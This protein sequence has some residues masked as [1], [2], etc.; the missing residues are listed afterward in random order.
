MSTPPPY[1][2]RSNEYD[3]SSQAW[4]CGG[5]AHGLPCPL[6]PSQLGVC[7]AVCTPVKD[8]DRYYCNHASELAGTCDEGP[9]PDGECCQVPPQCA[10]S[11]QA[12]QWVCNRGKCQ[13]GPLPDGTCSMK[14]ASCRPVRGVMA[15][16]RH[17]VFAVLGLAL[18]GL[19]IM[20]SIPQRVDIVSPGTLTS[21]H[22]GGSGCQDC[23]AIGEGDL[24]DWVDAALHPASQSSQSERCLKCHQELGDSAMFAH[25]LAPELLAQTTHD[26]STPTDASS[27][28]LLL[29][30]ARLTK[31]EANDE[32]ACRSC[33]T[34]H[35]GENFD[36]TAMVDLKCQLCHSQTFSSFNHGHPEI[37]DYWYPRRTRL[38]FNHASHE[39]VHAANFQ[40][41]T[42]GVR[43]ASEGAAHAL[44]CTHCHF[45]DASGKSMLTRGYEE[46]CASCHDHQIVDHLAS[47]IE[48]LR[49]PAP[50]APANDAAHAQTPFMR[51]LMPESVAQLEYETEAQQDTLQEGPSPTMLWSL[52]S[53]LLHH[54]RLGLQQRLQ[55]SLGS[56]ATPEDIERLAATLTH[57]DLPFAD[58]RR[59]LDLVESK[60]NTADDFLETDRVEET[61]LT[62]QS[63]WSLERSDEVWT[64][65]Y[66]PTEHA[67]P[68]LKVCLEVGARLTSAETFA[69]REVDEYPLTSLFRQ[70]A[71]PTFTGRCL[72]CHTAETDMDGYL[73]MVWTAKHS[74][75]GSHGFT[76]FVHDPHLT[77]GDKATCR[78][79]HPVVSE[80][81]LAFFQPE[82][83][84][85]DN[86]INTDASG[87]ET[88][89]FLALEKAA[90]ADCHQPDK[91]GESCL[92][93]HMYHAL[94]H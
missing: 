21:H 89:G 6:G 68:L 53:D 2:F 45:P 52:L 88:S 56:H 25:S 48:V 37:S 47:P 51:L 15:L 73:K 85:R 17:I 13:E 77:L 61:S 82:F 12:G 14:F 34:E 81:N 30:V 69:A 19:L 24:L 38:H 66:R 31:P 91:A 41:T 35:R 16:R 90:C 1:Q 27:R 32:L 62:Q 63:A 7:Q 84:H 59:L 83:M 9:L 49:I 22:Q 93:C 65:V 29:Q 55:E 57:L 11:K 72:K 70:L 4:T 92:T 54:N 76:E 74:P 75:S 71:K 10:P 94:S 39:I 20:T 78:T 64:L 5:E 43:D 46:S 50:Q 8:G 79:C 80:A 28:S 86:T 58:R 3:R 40:R 60:L 67:D 36:M 44:S 18:G 26:A 33:H 42:P 87:R 23:H